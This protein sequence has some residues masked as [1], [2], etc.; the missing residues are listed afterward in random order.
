MTKYK[1]SPGD[2]AASLGER[3]GHFWQTIWDHPANSELREK[4]KSAET[5]MPNLDVEIRS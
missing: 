1:L 3:F 2:W 5:L 4:C